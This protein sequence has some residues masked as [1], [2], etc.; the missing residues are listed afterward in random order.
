LINTLSV[1]KT[2]VFCVNGNEAATP[3][4]PEPSPENEPENEP[5]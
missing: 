2:G 4:N 5:E 1:V 3:D